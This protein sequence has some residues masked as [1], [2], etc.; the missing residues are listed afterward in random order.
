MVMMTKTLR[1]INLPLRYLFNYI[2]FIF[3][4]LH[5][6]RRSTKSSR[7]VSLGDISLLDVTASSQTSADSELLPDVVV[8]KAGTSIPID[9]TV[10]SNATDDDDDDASSACS[11]V[12]VT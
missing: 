12:T 2:I 11:G 1:G 7:H 9:N 3:S 6:R 5:K 4:A 8:D 10:P